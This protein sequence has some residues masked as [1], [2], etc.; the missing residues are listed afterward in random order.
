VGV[1]GAKKTKFPKRP[2]WAE[3]GEKKVNLSSPPWLPQGQGGTKKVHPSVHH[4]STLV[5]WWVSWFTL[6]LSPPPCTNTPWS[7]LLCRN[8]ETI[9][10]QKS[11]T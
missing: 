10:A 4:P 8:P 11:W 3:G 1:C 2:T 9:R 5:R 6:A 7:Y